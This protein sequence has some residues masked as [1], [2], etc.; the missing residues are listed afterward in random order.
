MSLFKFGALALASTGVLA[1]AANAQTSTQCEVHIYP[2]DGVHSVGEDFDA[3]KRVDQDL[4]HYYEM[5]GRP[6][7]WLTP[8]RQGEIL[9][10]VVVGHVLG[11]SETSRVI[12]A[13][14]LTRREAIAA[15]PKAP[16]TAACTVEV[17]LPQ[18]M[19]ERGGL[20]ERSVR[21]FGV[22]R[23]F[24]NGTQVS[25]FSSYGAAPM[26]GFQLRSPAE[27]EKATQIVE[28]A[29]RGAVEEL[30]QNSAKQKRK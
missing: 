26:P 4:K 7:D 3:T 2:A 30:L 8:R 5:A 27:A 11:I 9:S 29:Y 10:E 24:E 25:T 17:M 13:N 14:F 18:I 23:R 6:L 1:C 20:A 12:H 15:G 16:S 28:A 19:L 21:V 22:V